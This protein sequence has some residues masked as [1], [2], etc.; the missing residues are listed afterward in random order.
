MITAAIIQSCLWI[1]LK[2]F[3]LNIKLER[4]FA[5]RNVF[6]YIHTNGY[7]KINKEFWNVWIMWSHLKTAFNTITAH[8]SCGRSFRSWLVSVHLLMD[9]MSQLSSERPEFDFCWVKFIWARSLEINLGIPTMEKGKCIE[10]SSFEA[11]SGYIR[12]WNHKEKSSLCPRAWEPPH[13]ESSTFTLI[14]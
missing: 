12:T 2:Q 5:W 13:M 1:H 6:L 3:I 14:L 10:H 11:V 7:P 4:R 8:T 9:V